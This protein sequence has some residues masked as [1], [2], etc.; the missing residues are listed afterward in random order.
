[1]DQ[2]EFEQV[3]D[4]VIEQSR[5]VLVEKAREYASDG[6]RMHNFKRAAGFTGGTP[7]QALWGFLTKHLVSLSDMVRSEKVYPAEVWDEK[8]GDALNYL[9]LL[10]ALVF[11]SEYERSKTDDV[12]SED[13]IDYSAAESPLRVQLH[14]SH[15]NAQHLGIELQNGSHSG[16]P[17]DTHQE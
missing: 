1:M 9:I 17:T 5:A 16:V 6:D 13:A 12:A 11:D 3:F 14:T 2:E 10:R 7:E 15:D 4:R 8:L